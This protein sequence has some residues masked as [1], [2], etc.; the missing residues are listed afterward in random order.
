[1]FI[2]YQD[3][4]YNLITTNFVFVYWNGF[5]LQEDKLSYQVAAKEA[6]Q[7]LHSEKLEALAHAAEQ[8]RARATAEQEAQ[9]ARDMLAETQMEITVIKKI[10]WECFLF[11]EFFQFET[12]C[13]LN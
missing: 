1:M 12:Q 5:A 10:I 8:E 7:K 9:L 4:V 13:T 2:N 6:L 11:P 3:I